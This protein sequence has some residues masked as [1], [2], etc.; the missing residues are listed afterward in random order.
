MEQIQDD[1]RNIL[2]H[3]EASQ[4]D[5]PVTDLPELPRVAD[6]DVFVPQGMDEPKIYP[7]D[8]V[9]GVN[10]DEIQFA[11]LVYMSTDGGV[12]ILPLDT[13]SFEFVAEGAFGSRFYKTDEIHVYGGVAETVTDWD[14][15]FD[16]FELE[17]PGTGRPR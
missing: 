17:R 10:D 15:E 1:R 4:E 8:V 12:L 9:V 16:E 2:I 6:A 7:G 14:V 5:L 11:E 13:G 3:P